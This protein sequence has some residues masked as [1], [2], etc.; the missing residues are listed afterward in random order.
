MELFLVGVCLVGWRAPEAE[1]TVKMMMM[2]MMMNCY[3]KAAWVELAV[4]VKPERM[5]KVKGGVND[6]IKLSGIAKEAGKPMTRHGRGQGG[7]RVRP[8]CCCC[9]P[10][11]EAST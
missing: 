4:H 10:Q 2:M 6:K 9:C 5:E 8:V 11:P 7:R 3:W 1:S